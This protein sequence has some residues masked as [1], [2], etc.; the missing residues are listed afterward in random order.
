MQDNRH[1]HRQG[2]ALEVVQVVSKPET[3]LHEQRGLPVVSANAAPISRKDFE[4]IPTST[5]FY[6]DFLE[7][8]QEALEAGFFANPYQKSGTA[9]PAPSWAS[10]S[11]NGCGDGCGTVAVTVTERLR[12]GCGTV[13]SL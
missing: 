9:F 5:N 3:N 1:E 8:Q 4:H 11:L 12:N 7:N 6:N 13:A 2:R 10:E